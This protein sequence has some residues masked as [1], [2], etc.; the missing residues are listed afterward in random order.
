MNKEREG[1]CRRR[2]LW[3][4]DVYTDDSDPLAVA[5]HAGWIRGYWGEGVDFSWLDVGNV[6]SVP[7]DPTTNPTITATPSESTLLAPPRK[8]MLPIPGKDLHLTILILPTLQ[9]YTSLVRYGIKS[10]PWGK[11][12]DGMSF[13]IEK[14]AWVDEGAGQGEER[15]GE[16]R[17]KR[18]KMMADEAGG[19]P[20]HL[21]MMQKT[22]RKA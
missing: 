19:L 10:R 2:I 1:V 13:K 9:N 17:R 18:M 21:D 7:A 22:E 14:I 15:G 6:N 11:T 4:A 5:M 3:G 20:L 12:H 16:A 8:P